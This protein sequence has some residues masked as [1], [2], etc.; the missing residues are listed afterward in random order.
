MENKILDLFSNDLFVKAT[1]SKPRSKTADLKNVY[2]E[3]IASLEEHPFKLT[4]RYT[5]KDQTKVMT[6]QELG[7]AVAQYLQD[8]FYFADFYI[9]DAIHGLKQSKKG[10][11]T[12]SIKKTQT[13]KSV[14]TSHDKVKKR[15][16]DEDADFLMK[17]GLSSSNGRIFHQSQAKYK[18]INRYVELVSHLLPEGLGKLDIADMGSGKGYLTFALY[19]YL[20]EKGVDVKM[21]GI[22]MRPDLIEKC[23]RIARDL[24]KDGL[25]F[26]LGNIL[27]AEIGQK[28]MVIALHACD[29]ATDMAIHKALQADAQYIVLA[30]CCHKQVR[31][32]MQVPGD[33]K[34]MLRHG[35]LL[36]RQAEMLTD[37]I[38][39]LLLE[40]NGYKTQVFEFISSEHTGKNVMITAIK[41]NKANPLALQQ[42]EN[43]K[44]TFGLKEHYLESLLAAKPSL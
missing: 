32:A 13:S 41:T 9:E 8:D 17:L 14:R 5:T 27:D 11:S 20:K 34:A 43:L 26:E 24:N 28:D 21:K 12:W 16:I 40:A 42:I 33:L 7:T 4:Y 35:I 44:D 25:S 31:K 39:A 1:L 22:E 2:I 36:E 23:N 19:H 29:I 3:K 37:S 6:L 15:P 10:K 30:P 18:Q 38:R